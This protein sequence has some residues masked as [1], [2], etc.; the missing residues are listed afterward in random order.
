MR[1]M[2]STG[3]GPEKSDTASNALPSHMSR[4]PPITSRTIGSSASTARGVNA[5]LTRDRNLSW[6]GGSIMMMLCNWRINSGGLL[7]VERSTPWLDEKVCHS[8]CAR[9]TSSYRNN[10]QN[11]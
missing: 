2:I 3:N 4:A 7:K 8:L 5:R 9:L 1:E 11:P 10:A 6:S